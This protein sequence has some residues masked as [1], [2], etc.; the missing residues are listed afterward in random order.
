M[1]TPFSQLNLS[2]VEHVWAEY[3]VAESTHPYGGLRISPLLKKFVPE[4]KGVLL[5]CFVMEVWSAQRYLTLIDCGLVYTATFQPM[6]E[7][8][9]LQ[10]H[11]QIAEIAVA[12]RETIIH[13]DIND[14]EVEEFLLI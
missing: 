13:Y 10:R 14:L 8:L 9:R 6:G 2:S 12:C 1:K 3:H 7:I 5:K 4:Y 11:W